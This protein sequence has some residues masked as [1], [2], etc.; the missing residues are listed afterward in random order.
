MEAVDTAVAPPWLHAAPAVADTLRPL[1]GPRD[2]CGTATT[3]PADIMNRGGVE[4]SPAVRTAPR[5]EL[6]LW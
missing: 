4:M 2:S 5:F 1:E 3:G 6:E